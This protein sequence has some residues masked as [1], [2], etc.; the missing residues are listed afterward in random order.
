MADQPCTLAPR[1]PAG[2]VDADGRPV[3]HVHELAPASPLQPGRGGGDRRAIRH[4]P[5]ALP[6]PPLLCRLGLH[7]LVVTSISSRRRA[8]AVELCSAT[9]TCRRRRC[10]MSRHEQHRAVPTTP[11]RHL[12]AAATAALA[13]AVAAATPALHALAHHAIRAS[14]PGRAAR[15]WRDRR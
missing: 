2:R 12:L 3:V 4:A 9:S 8:G 14:W 13:P 5:P 6:E 15:V 1:R 7:H 11:A 10:A